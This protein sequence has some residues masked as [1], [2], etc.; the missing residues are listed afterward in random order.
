MLKIRM[1]QVFKSDE[2]VNFRFAN[3]GYGADANLKLTSDLNTSAIRILSIFHDHMTDI[4][5]YAPW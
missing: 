4:I 1:A 3:V 5:S 2:V